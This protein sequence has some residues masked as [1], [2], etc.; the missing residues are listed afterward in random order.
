MYILLHSAT[1]KSLF[2][3][4][5]KL[6]SLILIPKPKALKTSVSRPERNIAQKFFTQRLFSQ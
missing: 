1:S 2:C 5:E 3:S 6:I 4:Q